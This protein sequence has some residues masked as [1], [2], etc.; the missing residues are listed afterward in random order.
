MFSVAGLPRTRNSQCFN[1]VSTNV[2]VWIKNECNKKI[3]EVVYRLKLSGSLF[4]FYEPVNSI[5]DPMESI[6]S[7]LW[8]LKGQGGEQ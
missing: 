6:M 8:N 5:L 7:H 3:P 4:V 1:R 2:P